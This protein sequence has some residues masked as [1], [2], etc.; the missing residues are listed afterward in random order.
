MPGHSLPLILIY[1]S[2]FGTRMDTSGTGPGAEVTFDRSRMAEADAVLFHIPDAREIGDARKY[3]GQCWIA[4]SM[5]SNANYPLLAAPD[6]MR[7][8]DVTM[9]YEQESDVWTPYL[10]HLQWWI[11]L[12]GMPVPAKTEQAPVVMFQSS[13]VDRSGRE[14]LAVELSKHIGIDSYGRFMRNRRVEGPDLGRRTKLDIISRYRFCLAFENSIA[15]DYVTEKLYDALLVGAVPVYLGAPNVAEFAPLGSF[16]NASEFTSPADLAAYLQHLAETPE[17]Y[18]A[19]FDWRSKPLPQGFVDLTRRAEVAA[20]PRLVEMVRSHVA[21]SGG[22]QRGAASFP[23]GYRAFLRTR[24]R[25]WCRHLQ[26]AR[27]G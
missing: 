11:D 21:A 19:Y 20:F 1:T 9:T 2:M 7:H 12:Q 10:P 17:A 15:R 22:V 27:S 23:F 14:S 8:F 5:E 26:G 3:P 6:F 13:G 24:L 4:W 25:R 18:A 16:I